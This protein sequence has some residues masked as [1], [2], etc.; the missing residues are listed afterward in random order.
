MEV[1]PAALADRKVSPSPLP[2]NLRIRAVTC[3]K[4]LKFEK[5]MDGS[6]GGFRSLRGK[7]PGAT[8]SEEGL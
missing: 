7:P 3:M 2:D 5:V 4:P 1:V 8:R 6:A